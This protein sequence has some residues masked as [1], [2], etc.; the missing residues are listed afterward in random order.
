MDEGGRVEV[1]SKDHCWLHLCRRA[2]EWFDVI[3]DGPVRGCG[4]AV[5]GKL[6]R[7]QPEGNLQEA[8]GRAMAW[9]DI[10]GKT[11]PVLPL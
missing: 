9:Q 3:Y 8:K 10:D 6:L 1:N 4:K 11:Q 5:M 2:P 7:L